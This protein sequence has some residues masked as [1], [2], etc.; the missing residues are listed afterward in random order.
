MNGELLETL[1]VDRK[2]FF[3]KDITLYPSSLQSQGQHER[4]VFFRVKLF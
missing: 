2:I 1:I 3:E 4:A